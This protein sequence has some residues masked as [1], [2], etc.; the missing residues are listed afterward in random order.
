MTPA[1]TRNAQQTPIV[2]PA[3]IPAPLHHVRTTCRAC[4]ADSLRRFLALGPQPLANAFPRN[5]AETSAEQ[6]FPLDV[7]FCE[8]CSLVQLADVIDPI[9]LFSDYI[10]VTGTSATIAEHNER[11]AKAVAE[12]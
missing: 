11:Y 12:R 4:G 1:A 7:Y 3:Q 5:Q 6:F 10:Y 8:T 2:S 9:V